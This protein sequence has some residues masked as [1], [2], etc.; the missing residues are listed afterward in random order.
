MTGSNERVSEPGAGTTRPIRVA[1]FQRVVPEY[2]VGVFS[3]LARQP[4][5]QLTIYSGSFSARP[6][7][8]ICLRTKGLRLGP[9]R[10]HFRPLL[11]ML[12]RRHDVMICEG[13]VSLLTS[14]LLSLVGGAV[15]PRCVWWTSLHRA[16]GVIALRG[17]VAGWLTRLALRRASA[18]LT[19]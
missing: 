16:D 15:G 5:I 11:A 4:G 3:L 2:R 17:G 18:I 9:L 13:R 14:M 10:L 7:G 12:R 8:A 19:Y 1:L 6:A